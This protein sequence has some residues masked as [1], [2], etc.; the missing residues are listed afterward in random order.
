M[1][2]KIG[3]ALV[4]AAALLL[5]GGSA[6]AAKPTATLISVDSLQQYKARGGNGG[7]GGGGGK[8]VP[9]A[10][11]EDDG[12]GNGDYGT[13]GWVVAGNRTAHLNTSTIPSGLTQAAVVASVQDAFDVWENAEAAAP[14]FN[15]ATDGAVRRYTANRQT[16]LLFG[17]TGSS[18]AT[19]YTWR[20]S[21]G[22]IESDVVFNSNLA[23]FVAGAEGDGCDE[24]TPKYEVGNI[25]AH[26]FGHVYGLGHSTGRFETMYSYGFTGETLKQSPS[27]GDTAGIRSLY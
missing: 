5:A 24:S 21:D 14:T 1:R 17:K 18:I 7:G 26:E 12:A 9:T 11:C 19:T 2:G 22:L 8:P 27:T 13:T 25:A 16:D 4:A 15:V 6:E 20:W 23:W 10:N 3:I